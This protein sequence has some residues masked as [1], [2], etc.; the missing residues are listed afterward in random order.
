MAYPK[1][2]LGQPKIGVSRDKRVTLGQAS[3]TAM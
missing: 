2:S 1:G 3:V